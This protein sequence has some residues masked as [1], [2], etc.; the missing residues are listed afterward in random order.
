L[1]AFLAIYGIVTRWRESAGRE[2]II[3]ASLVFY[4]FWIPAYLI[5]IIG[6]IV[7]NFAMAQFMRS[8]TRPKTRRVAVVLAVSANLVLLGY[9]KYLDFLIGSFGSLF[10][11]DVTLQ[12]IALPIGISFFTF[13][14]ISFQLDQYRGRIGNVK[15][16]DYAMLIAF[17]PHLIA[18]PIVLQSDLLPQIIGRKAWLLRAPN[19]A[20]GFA[21][22]SVGLFKKLV[23]SD[24]I[25]PYSDHVFSLVA[26]HGAASA[27]DAWAGALSYAFQIYFDFSG[28]SDMAVGLAFL[29][30]FRLPINFFSPY[31]AKS[32]QDFW[33]RWHIT[34]SNFLRNNLYFPLGGSRRGIR[35]TVVALLVTMTLGG[36]WHGAGITYVVWGIFHGVLLAAYHLY[37][38]SGIADR[39]S[40]SRVERFSTGAAWRAFAAGVRGLSTACAVL[41]TFSAVTIGWVYFRSPDLHTANTMLAAMLGASSHAPVAGGL[42]EV[43]PNL[44]LYAAMIWFLPNSAQIFRKFGMY[45]HAEEY[46]P[47]TP[48]SAVSGVLTYDLKPAW[49]LI[50]AVT[51]TIAWF[52]LSNLSPFIYFQF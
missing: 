42:H 50:S 18:G 49:A 37:R 35:R 45:Q 31:K 12:H 40:L 33:R 47:R 16:L 51:F 14:Q 15:F 2:L 44:L 6:S 23:L 17:F 32:I 39:L 26:S 8:T 10:S 20:L 3:L 7:C 48:V 38:R 52:A 46:L 43:W 1:L 11:L 19:I 27:A 36:L 22:F 5:L 29:F 25:S 41:V 34:L 4:G 9:F 24:R 30:G 13:Q 28:Y 21:V